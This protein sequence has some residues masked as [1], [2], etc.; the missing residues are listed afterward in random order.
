MEHELG[1]GDVV[2]STTPSS[3]EQTQRRQYGRSTVY[4]E[5]SPTVYKAGDVVHLP[6]E[7]NEKSTME[8]VGLAWAAYASGIPAQ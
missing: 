1:F 8:A 4:Y 6:Y 7:Q 3:A 5:G 2:E